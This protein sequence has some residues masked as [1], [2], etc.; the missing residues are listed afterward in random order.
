MYLCIYVHIYIHPHIH[1]YV[2]VHVNMY[3][4]AY[5]Y[6]YMCVISLIQQCLAYNKQLMYLTFH[7]EILL[8]LFV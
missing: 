5:A 6:M 8:E 4:N 3:V 1:I 7:F 2:Y